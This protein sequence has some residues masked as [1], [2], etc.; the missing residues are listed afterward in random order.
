MTSKL[1]MT[2]IYILLIVAT[3]I[4]VFPLLW[5]VIAAT[6]KSVEVISGKLTFG[7]NIIEN[8]ASEKYNKLEEEIDKIV[9]KEYGK[10]YGNKLLEGRHYEIR[11]KTLIEKN[12]KYKEKFR[13]S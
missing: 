10:N 13:A 2:G 1:K 12:K 5:M 8:K 3:I 7:A 4:S 6:N 9:T 11:L